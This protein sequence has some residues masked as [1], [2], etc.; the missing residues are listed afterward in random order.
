MKITSETWLKLLERT[1]FF[2][3]EGVYCHKCNLIFIKLIYFSEMMKL[4]FL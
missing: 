3:N 1:L 2:I 4:F